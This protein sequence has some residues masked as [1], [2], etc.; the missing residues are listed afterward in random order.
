MGVQLN[1]MEDEGLIM[2]DEVPFVKTIARNIFF[3]NDATQ[4]E[5]SSTV[6]ELY[7][8][9]EE[10][11]GSDELNSQSNVP[12]RMQIQLTAQIGILYVDLMLPEHLDVSIT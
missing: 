6:F 4:S 2:D 9:H 10:T 11:L 5:A 3:I 12:M 8:K 1:T 7:L